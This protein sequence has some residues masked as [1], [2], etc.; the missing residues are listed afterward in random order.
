MENYFVRN[1]ETRKLELHFEKETYQA[2]TEEQKKDIKSN[3]L[4][5]RNSGCWI[6]RAK[7]P[8]LLWAIRCAERLGLEDAGKEGERLSYAEQ[9]ERKAERAERRADRY[10]ERAAAAESRGEALQKPIN[11]MHGDIAFFTQP[12]INT[13][14]GQAF[15]NRRN[16]MF[17]SFEK[18]FEEFRKSTY[19]TERAET[20]RCTA[21]QKELKDKGF[22][23]RRIKERE[24]IIRKLKKNIEEYES[25]FK[26]IE[27]GETPRN[28]YGWEV[29]MTAE[30]VQKNIEYWLDRLEA[31]LDELGFYQ[32]CLDKL[33]GVAFS[34]DNI[35][36]GYIVQVRYGAGEVISTGPKNCV[37]K[38]GD[39]PLTYAYAEI[40]KVLKAEETAP[41]MHPYKVGETFQTERWNEETRKIETV[42]YKV[43]KT[44]DKTVTLQVGEEK[45]I[46][47]KPGRKAWGAREWY[48]KVTD[49]SRG[50]WCKPAEQKKEQPKEQK[51]ELPALT[52]EEF[53]ATIK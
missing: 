26:Q 44:T 9:M 53:A 50:I 3:F 40:L 51:E 52:P 8:N 31:R 32:D 11:D 1:L 47:R 17:A 37:V 29:E 23:C 13:S 45:P 42:E 4:W 15:T 41:E 30:E 12:N 49:L 18:G 5:G 20:A 25:Y 28:K 38:T 33:G 48:L 35:K 6:S 10:E 36:P 34:R 24:S 46:N 39:F 21:S 16:R 14:A 22:L 43:I 7:E 27:K 19:W 2:L